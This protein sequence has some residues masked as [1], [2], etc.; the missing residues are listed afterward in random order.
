[1][2]NAFLLLLLS[3]TLSCSIQPTVQP[4]YSELLK[5]GQYESGDK[6]AGI[7]NLSF[8]FRDGGQKVPIDN[9]GTISYVNGICQ[10]WGYNYGETSG[11]NVTAKC[12]SFNFNN[13]KCLTYKAIIPYVCKK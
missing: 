6:E 7:V 8:T 1:M 2:K 13:G 4:Q 11:G 10:N 9:E 3:I 5:I 12:V